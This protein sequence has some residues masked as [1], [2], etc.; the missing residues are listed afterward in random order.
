GRLT[1]GQ[2]V[3]SQTIDIPLIN[4]NIVEADE[5]FTVTLTNATGGA[6]LVPGSTTATAWIIDD[7]LASGKADFAAASYSTNESAGVGQ[8][9][10]VRLGGNQ[11]ELS[12]DVAVNAGTAT[13]GVDFTG[14]TTN[15]TWV[16]GDIDPKIIYVPI[17]NDLNVE[18]N[19]TVLLQLLNPSVFMG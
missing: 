19:E 11:G 13:A 14:G 3:T 9:A 4:D 18:P 6:V 15:V 16:D 17:V 10:V 7:D 5:F 8:I 2:S 12:V 1:F